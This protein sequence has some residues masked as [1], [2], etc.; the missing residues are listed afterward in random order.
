MPHLAAALA[1]VAT[2]LLTAPAAQ[3][4]FAPTN[5]QVIAA[6]SFFVSGVGID[7][8]GN[9]LIAWEEENAS[10]EAKA[11]R[12]SVTGALGP[13]ID[14]DPGLPGQEPV[15]AMAASGR[16]FVAWRAPLEGNPFAAGVRGRWVEPNGSLGPVLTL[17]V[18][19][20]NEVAAAGLAAVIDPA[21]IAT[22]TWKNETGGE[23]G[24]LLLRRVQP[25]GTLGTLVPDVTG[26]KPTE[27]KIAALPNGSTLVTW[28][29]GFLE[30]AI[31]T[32]D[33]EISAPQP[34]SSDNASGEIELRVDSQ[35][36]TLATWRQGVETTFSIRGRLFDPAGGFVGEELIFDPNL[37]GIPDNRPVVSDSLNDFLISWV[38]PDADGDN[39][40]Y[41]RPFSRLT[42]LMGPT[43]TVSNPD[44]SSNTSLAAINDFGSGAVVWN[45]TLGMTGS[46]PYGREIDPLGV[47]TGGIQELF[48]PR[49]ALT[50][51]I[52]SPAAGVAVFLLGTP[53][54]GSNRTAIA[55]R[56]LIAP[57]CA[58]SS[59]EVIQGKPIEASLACSGPGIEGAKV[60]EPPKQGSVGAFKAGPSLEYV[61]KP[62]FEGTDSFTYTALNDGGASNVARVE[63]KVRKDTVKPT[64]ERFR[65][66]R[67]TA[68]KRGAR[69]SAKK[70]KQPKPSYSFA[71]RISEAALAVVTIER[72]A[73]GVRQGKRCG[74]PKPGVEGKR[75]T[76]FVK[77]GVVSPK[78][79]SEDLTIRVPA[80]LAK[81]LAKGGRFRATALATDLAGNRSK[82]KAITLRIQAKK[83]KKATS[84]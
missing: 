18:G 30:K 25:D 7:G 39:V 71:L 20:A 65:F 4:G 69:L 67:G 23:G 80:K 11:R 27:P 1:L 57:T 16:A 66:V 22:V 55:R 48:S 34:M 37:P 26:S 33:L 36:N 49:A 10:R 42:G 13:V 59:A 60:I 14:L 41:A 61:P 54:I 72:S 12:L 43:Q 73:P 45:E 81:R 68:K 24:Q 6:P 75:C 21:G 62:G 70:G 19:K 58:N 38:R 9:S 56:F 44:Q 74:K 50:N 63:I 77:L 2:L 76:R 79:A 3:A 51:S 28:R 40:V 47:P 32:A 5:E 52:S 31:V 35:G 53:K 82:P 8:K 83:K 84:P 29:S 64:I 78:T 17:I 46:I 15:V